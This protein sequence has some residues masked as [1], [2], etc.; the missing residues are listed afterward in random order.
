[1]HTRY[2]RKWEIRRKFNDRTDSTQTFPEFLSNNHIPT[3]FRNRNKERVFRRNDTIN[4]DSQ[5]T[6]TP[7]TK[8]PLPYTRI[9]D[10]IVRVTTNNKGVLYIEV[11]VE[12]HYHD[13]HL[14]DCMDAW[15][16]T[17]DGSLYISIPDLWVDQIELGR[18]NGTLLFM[19]ED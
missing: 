15:I 3:Y 8:N 16:N 14:K 1:M 17:G 18:D 2:N 9:H 12:T 10:K 19:I 13:Y 6:S 11:N 4:R 5:S 7:P